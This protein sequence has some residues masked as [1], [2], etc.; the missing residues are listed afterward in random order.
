VVV[1]TLLRCQFVGYEAT[2]GAV[3]VTTPSSILAILR[4]P[5]HAFDLK[6][7]RWRN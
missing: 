1:P 4:S 2:E 3:L 7:C 6:T 5:D